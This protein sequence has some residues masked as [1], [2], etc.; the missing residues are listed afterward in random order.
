MSG[1]AEVEDLYSAIEDSARLLEVPCSRDKIW[2]ILAAYREALPQAVIA[3]RVATG[4]RLA[5]E[6]DWRFTIP[7]DV[8]PYRIAVASGLTPRTDHPVS[9]V[10][11]DIQARCPIGSYGIDF[12]VVGGF[13]K[14]YAFFPPENMQRLSTLVESPSMP[15]GL[16]EKVGFFARHGLDGDKVNLVGVDYPHRTVNVYF[17]ALPDDCLKEESVRAMLRELRLPDPSEQMLR[18][19]RHAFGIYVTLSWDSPRIERFCFAVMPPDPAALPIPLEPK[20]ESFLRSVPYDGAASRFIYYAAVSSTEQ[21]HYKLQSYYR[22]Q[23]RMLDQML[24]SETSDSPV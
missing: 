6:L 4:V 23:P 17:G 7:R 13:K 18:L 24:L 11:E 16:A 1:T 2:P 19:G 8:D 20:I 9:Q 14:I 10:L 21:E 15:P 3:F 12:G 5:G 22:W